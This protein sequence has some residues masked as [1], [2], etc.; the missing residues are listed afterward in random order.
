LKRAAIGTGGLALTRPAT[1]PWAKKFKP[2]MNKV[3]SK[4]A[5]IITLSNVNLPDPRQVCIPCRTLNRVLSGANFGVIFLFLLAGLLRVEGKVLH[6][7][8]DGTGDF[9]NVQACVNAMAGGDSCLVA[10]GVYPERIKFPAGKSGQAGALTI[11][12]AEFPGTAAIGGADTLNCDYLRLQGFNISVPGSLSGWTDSAGI[13]IRSS[14]VEVVSNY[15]QEIHSAAISGSGNDVIVRGNHVFKCGVGVNLSGSGW[16]VDGN[17][18]ERLQKYPELEVAGNLRFFGQNHVLRNNHFFGTLPA[19]TGAA[20]VDGFQTF[21]TNGDS[22]QHIVIE[23]NLLEGY[24]HQ[25]VML[26]AADHTN[27]FDIAIRNNI[28]IAPASYAVC[29]ARNL[30]EIKVYNNTIVN[31]AIFGVRFAD[32]SR[33]EARNNVFYSDK[34]G[35]SDGGIAALFYSAGASSVVVGDRNLLY[36][37]NKTIS[38]AAFPN[39]LVNEDPRFVSLVTRNYRLRPGSPG[40]NAGATLAGFNEDRA[41][42]QRPQGPAWDI[43]AYEFSSANAGKPS[44]PASLRLNP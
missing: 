8:P 39:D 36:L 42:T 11:L 29:V 37:A 3:I 4:P 44:P 26:D 32:N 30:R 10:P 31:P 6:V 12:Q 17:D 9:T 2:A 7:R 28:F 40:I 24:Y 22:A 5:R 1:L 43:G 38:P 23:N 18:I 19:E 14:H 34:P 41:G 21:D 35:V 15:L 20:Q 16:L 13:A 33:G 25:G 27:T